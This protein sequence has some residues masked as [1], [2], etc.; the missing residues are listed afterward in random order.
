MATYPWAMG[1]ASNAIMALALTPGIGPRNLRR[2][3]GAFG[4]AEKALDASAAAWKERA[5]VSPA[6]KAASGETGAVER[7]LRDCARLGYKVLTLDDDEYPSALAAIYDP[8]PVLYLRGTLPPP[9]ALERSVAIV[10]TR[11]P[12]SHGLTFAHRLSAE[13]AGAGAVVVSGLAIGI[14]TEVHRAVVAA[15]AVG[16]AIV[17]GS[18][19]DVHPSV[20]R[21]LAEQLCRDGCLV[22]EH[23]PGTSLRR[24]HFVGRNRLIS[25]ISKIV[26]VVEAGKGSGALLTADF[27]LDQGRTVFTMPGRPG[28]AR[29]AGNLRLLHEGAGI[30]LSSADIAYEL[31]LNVVSAAAREVPE[32]TGGRRLFASGSASFDA[33]LAAS[34]LTPPELL[35]RLGRLELSG[36]IRRGADGLYYLLDG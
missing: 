2:L 21:R 24:G 23:P 10:G 34:G 33:M 18:L 32:I 22:S 8:P 11:K 35:A 27:A 17:P 4:S 28:D 31:G 5:G 9:A 29:V 26:A 15:G 6:L 36:R 7:V 16:I 13:L 30:L 14:D 20:N 25:G 19:H 12:S 1:R 3:L